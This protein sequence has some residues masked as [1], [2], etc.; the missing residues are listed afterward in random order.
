MLTTV[1]FD[2]DDTLWQNEHYYKLS[3]QRFADLLADRAGAED[4]AKRLFEAE[5]RNIGRYGFGIKGFTLSMIETALELSGGNVDA[6][7]IKSIL[8]LGHAQM[9]HPV[10]LLPHA[11]ETIVML[12]GRYS[13]LLITKGD[14][15][16]QERKIAASGLGDY[17]D[18]IEVV[19]EKN[20]E[21]YQKLFARHGS[22]PETSAMVG[23]SLKSDVLPAIAAGGW[24]VYI[25]HDLTWAYEHAEAPVDEPRFR[26]IGH[27]GE[28]PGLL[29]WLE[30]VQS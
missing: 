19:S 12:E 20:A 5:K 9:S 11:L 1:A 16:D 27:L 23:N 4:V 3:Q 25:P 28:L 24:G 26:Q 30:A 2:A 22:G 18:A 10:D 21:T 29:E 8:E 17:F 14:L 7:K 6:T 13:L 15:Y